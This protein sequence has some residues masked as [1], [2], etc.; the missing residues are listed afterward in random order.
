M[1]F[2]WP[3]NAKKQAETYN[4]LITSAKPIKHDLKNSAEKKNPRLPLQRDRDRIV[5]SKSFKRLAHKTQ[6]FPH[7]YSDHQRQ[8]ESSTT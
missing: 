4:K 8:R 3:W 2:N 5:W 7:L 1:D 6:V